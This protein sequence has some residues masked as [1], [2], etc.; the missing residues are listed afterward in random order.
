MERAVGIRELRDRL[1]RYLGRVRRGERFVITNRG[2]PVAIIAPY[3]PADSRIRAER[4]STLLASGH[5]SP[6]EGRFLKR[7]PLVRGRG[8]FPSE[9]IAESRR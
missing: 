3:R 2:Q 9:L 8:R 1:T 5:V 6:A 4:L 7:P